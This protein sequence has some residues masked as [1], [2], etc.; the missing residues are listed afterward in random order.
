MLKI[1][2]DQGAKVINSW[3]IGC[4]ASLVICEGASVQR[5]LGH[6][7]TIVSVSSYLCHFCIVVL[8]SPKGLLPFVLIFSEDVEIFLLSIPC[9]CYLIALLPCHT[10]D[11]S[12]LDVKIIPT[13]EQM[14]FM[15]T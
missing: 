4:N 15:L 11:H 3:F 8:Y 9:K 14:C 6:A 2:G 13:Y 10:F 5:Y 7:N 1:A 12:E